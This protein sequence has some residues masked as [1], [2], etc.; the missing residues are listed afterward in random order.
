MSLF[1]AVILGDRA[2]LWPAAAVLLA[3]ALLVAAAYA[4]TSWPPVRRLAVALLKVAGFALVLLCLVEPLWSGSRS[5][6][7]ENLFV[8]LADDSASL[9]IADE[10]GGPT[11][12]A[13]LQQLLE[14]RPDG[15]WQTVLE[16]EFDVRRYTFA[17]R[18]ES[19][20]AFTG[21]KFDDGSSRLQSAA[22]LLRDRYRGR[23]V[24]GV[25]LFTDGNATDGT[26]DRELLN[27]L[28]PVYPVV[29]R[30]TP[31]QLDVG[32]ADVSVAYSPFE[33][34]PVTV[35]A[36]VRVIGAGESPEVIGRL[37][38]E[39]DTQVAE[40][41]G[42]PTAGGESLS[43]RFEVRPVT[44]GLEFYKLEVALAEHASQFDDAATSPEAVLANNSQL[45][46]IKQDAT[47]H[48]ILYVSGRPNF[49]FKF[50]RRS[51]ESDAALELVGLVRIARKEAKFE[52]RG[53][54]GERGNALFQGFGADPETDAEA[55][56]EPVIVRVGT[57]DEAEL[58]NGF[59]K[60]KEELYEYR[61]VIIDDVEAGFFS[62]DQMTLLEEYVSDRGGSLLMLGGPDTF[63]HGGYGRTG[64]ED[65]L[66]FYLR[67]GNPG[68]LRAGEYRWKLT[69]DG[70]L[71]PWVRLR[72]N[73][74]DE[75][76]RISSMPAFRS[77]SP[78]AEVKPAA[79]TLAEVRD[80][81]END[82]PAL[83]A[84]QYGEGRVAAL[85][86][87]DA[88]RWP[89]RRQEGDPE[90]YAKAWRQ[91]LRWLVVDVPLRLDVDAQSAT[92]S[93]ATVQLIA[94]IRDAAFEPVDGADVAFTVRTPDGHDYRLTAE[95]SLDEP[96]VYATDYA[97]RIAG[98]Y[99][100][101]VMVKD[102]EGRESQVETG[103]TSDP[104]AE[105]FR[106][107]R[108]NREGLAL[109]AQSTGGEVIAPENLAEFVASLPARKAP[110]MEVWSRPL[111][112]T[113]WMLL[114]AIGCF[115]A[116][117]ALRRRRGLP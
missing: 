34:A 28:G 116:E 94:R 85:L 59:P 102:A 41:R 104:A 4:R 88:W 7:G 86:V 10:P 101:T 67:R 55:Y 15:D 63:A 90:D 19:A 74:A 72:R 80:A 81:F 106:E 36:T 31:D 92:D 18:L 32:I 107:L 49:E 76:D 56:D 20:D 105:E 68:E 22:G 26:I 73:E 27:G 82:H 51:V 33:D 2:W 54:A 96:G 6:P 71:Q 99:R 11:R 87:G 52:F 12:G 47:A 117:W 8:I 45:V 21:L 13:Q 103:W 48:R 24:A 89:L 97:P 64:L 1:A 65:M 66:P 35:Q 110:I 109:L 84:H 50:L 25:L 53:R 62:H 95:P 77:L 30:E 37:L 9:Q 108:I 3:I 60:T 69:R 75:G 29:G 91:M 43:L 16:R 5:R 78:A 113:P 70:W 23:P 42:T 40:T 17:S 100:A 61:A 39:D 58:R 14:R 44:A 38:R 111:W 46:T 57:R 83:I 115:A 98:G 114:A 79:R 112:H 93:S